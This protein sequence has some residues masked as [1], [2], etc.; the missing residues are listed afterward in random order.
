MDQ[1]PSLEHNSHSASHEVP[2]L[3]WNPKVH[4]R[5]H[6]SPPV[7]SI[8]SQMN[9]I[10]IFPPYFPNVYSNIVLPDIASSSKISLSFRFS[11][12]N[13][14]RISYLSH[15]CYMSR[16]SHL[17]WFD[18]LNYIWWR[19][20]YGVLSRLPLEALSTALLHCM[21]TLELK[22]FFPKPYL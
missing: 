22:V 13:I 9:P 6:N 2:N 20:F 18:H 10:Y 1:S 15:A 21:Q 12:Q 17:P 5:V 4:Y 3:L 7:V 19:I 11:I 8:L 16:P 14:V